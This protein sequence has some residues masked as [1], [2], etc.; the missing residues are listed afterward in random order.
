MEIF[1]YIFLK[2]RQGRG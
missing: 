2:G 1:H